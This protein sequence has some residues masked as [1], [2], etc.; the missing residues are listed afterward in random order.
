[1]LSLY[2]GYCTILPMCIKEIERV[3]LFKIFKSSSKTNE[4]RYNNRYTTCID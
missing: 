3:Y 4:I 1:M 2:L